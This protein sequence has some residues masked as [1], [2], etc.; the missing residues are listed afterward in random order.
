MST[1][2]YDKA[3]RM[4]MHNNIRAKM[5]SDPATH[6]LMLILGSGLSLVTGFGYTTVVRTFFQNE[7]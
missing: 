2:V 4:D 5:L 7:K 1:G 6:P 3:I